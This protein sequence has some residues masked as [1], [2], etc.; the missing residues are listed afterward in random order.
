M[1][2]TLMTEAIRSYEKSV[3]T[4]ATGRNNPEEDFL[5]TTD[6]F[7]EA[8]Q[9]RLWVGTDVS[10]EMSSYSAIRWADS[11]VPFSGNP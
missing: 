1:F 2:V 9:Y 3:L 10:E 11:L 8:V 5:H 4:G 7:W 6:F